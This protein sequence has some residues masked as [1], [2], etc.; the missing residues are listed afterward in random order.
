MLDALRQ[1]L[2]LCQKWKLMVNR[3]ISTDHQTLIGKQR[4]VS[5]HERQG[6][7]GIDFNDIEKHATS[8]VLCLRDDIRL[9]MEEKLAEATE[10]RQ[11]AKD[12]LARLASKDE[13][14]DASG[15]DES[16]KKKKSSSSSSDETKVSLSDINQLKTRVKS[17]GITFHE[18]NL[19]QVNYGFIARL[20]SSSS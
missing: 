2:D 19:I 15:N 13:P 14:V 1:R 16:S 10:C 18:M 3:L 12:L 5:N 7:C 9:K 20:S 17:I 4:G 6:T 8:G 11:L